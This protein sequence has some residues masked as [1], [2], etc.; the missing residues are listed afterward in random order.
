MHNTKVRFPREIEPVRI[1]GQATVLPSNCRNCIF[2]P[3]AMPDHNN[4]RRSFHPVFASTSLVRP[5]WYMD[6]HNSPVGKEGYR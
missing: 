5:R 2:E 1:L 6:Q 4:G 3:L